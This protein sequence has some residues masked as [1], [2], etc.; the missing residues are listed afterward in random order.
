MLKI[1]ALPLILGAVLIGASP[2][3]ADDDAKMSIKIETEDGAKI[4]LET[5]GG[6]LQG[7]IGNADGRCEADRDRSPRQM[8]S[9]LT[10][11]GEGGVYRG[12]DEDGGD[13]TARRRGGMLRIE[14]PDD[15]GNRTLVEMPWDVAECLMSGIEPKGD[16]RGRLA[17]GEA[18]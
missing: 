1:S 18:K 8:M 3:L 16:I 7:L 13:F 15:D 10:R 12:E 4:E 2:L 6:W 5:G 9:S 11:Q 14:K 17:R